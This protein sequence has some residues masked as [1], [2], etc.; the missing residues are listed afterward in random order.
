MSKTTKYLQRNARKV[1]KKYKNYVIDYV[2]TCR[3][4]I[5]KLIVTKIASDKFID[6]T[7]KDSKKRELAIYISTA[8]CDEVMDTPEEFVEIYDALRILYG[9]LNLKPMLDLDLKINVELSFSTNNIYVDDIEY[10][11]QF[12]SEI[13]AQVN[14]VFVSNNFYS[15]CTCE[16]LQNIYVES[17]CLNSDNSYRLNTDYIE[18][19]TNVKLNLW[20]PIGKEIRKLYGEISDFGSF[21]RRYPRKF[22]DVILLDVYFKE[23]GWNFKIRVG[24]KIDNNKILTSVF[25]LKQYLNTNLLCLLNTYVRSEK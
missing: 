22:K 17:N 23:L 5:D 7:P 21:S 13:G 9:D 16:G 11:P 19:Y 10:V 15:I 24:D 18:S 3:N 6:V 1:L 12:L 4:K 20:N 14:E 25:E 2:S 8:L